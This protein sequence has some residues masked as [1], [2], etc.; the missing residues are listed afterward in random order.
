MSIYKF[1][2]FYF[3]KGG[4]NENARLT[5]PEINRRYKHLIYWIAYST[6]MSARDAAN[7]IAAF[8]DGISLKD[9]N[10]AIAKMGGAMQTMEFALHSYARWRA[11]HIAF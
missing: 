5:M 7:A 6:G 2:L 4:R 3:C 11:K 8:R 10:T 9:S 1:C